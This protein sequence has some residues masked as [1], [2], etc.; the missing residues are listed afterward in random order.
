LDGGPDDGG[1]EPWA[2]DPNA[3]AYVSDDQ[4]LS[5]TKSVAPVD[6]QDLVRKYSQVSSGNWTY[7]CY[8]YLP[9]DFSGEAYFIL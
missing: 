9:V 5:P 6:F 7:A 8:Q 2:G 1:W 3:G 4:S